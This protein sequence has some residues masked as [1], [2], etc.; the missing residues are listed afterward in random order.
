MMQIKVTAVAAAL[1]LIASLGGT[2]FT[3]E[4][5]KAEEEQ[6]D[7]SQYVFPVEAG[8]SVSVG[9]KSAKV[10]MITFLDYQCPFCA[11]LAD[12]QKQLRKD[13]D[14]KLRIVI[15]QFPLP[16]HQGADLISEAALAAAE[17]GKFWPM[18]LKLLENYKTLAISRRTKKEDLPAE[19]EKLKSTLVDYAGEMGMDKDKFK[20]ALDS[21]SVKDQIEADQNDAKAVKIMATPSTFING[22]LLMGAQPVEKFKEIIDEELGWAAKGKRPALKTAKLVSDVVKPPQRQSQGPDPNK[23]YTIELAKTPIMGSKDAKV[24]VVAFLDYQ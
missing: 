4:K 9:P 5:P 11:R 22:R 20:T 13:Y 17:Q 23:R 12:S 7:P 3:Q 19:L 8:T 2:A 10:T 14:D 24:T 6:A 21:K 18:H 15:K 1:L 16:F